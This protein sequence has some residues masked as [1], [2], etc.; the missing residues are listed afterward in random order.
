MSSDAAENALRDLLV[1]GWLKQQ[2]DGLK[3]L[4]SDIE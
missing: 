3:W 1:S 2:L 4:C